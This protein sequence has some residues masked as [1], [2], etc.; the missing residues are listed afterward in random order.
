VLDE[1]A[2]YLKASKRR[3]PR[4]EMMYQYIGYRQ[5]VMLELIERLKRR[6]LAEDQAQH[7]WLHSD[8]AVKGCLDC[9]QRAVAS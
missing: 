7:A 8:K 4:P 2:A 5:P 6:Q 9:D 3:R 1:I